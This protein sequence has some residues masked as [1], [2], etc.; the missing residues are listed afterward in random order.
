MRRRPAVAGKLLEKRTGAKLGIFLAMP[1]GG[2]HFASRRASVKPSRLQ[3]KR[4]SGSGQSGNAGSFPCH[5]RG[6]GNPPGHGDAGSS[7]GKSLTSC[8]VRGLG[9]TRDRAAAGKPSLDRQR[10][11]K[12]KQTS[13]PRTFCATPDCTGWMFTHRLGKDET[14]FCFKCNA[15]Y[16]SETRSKVPAVHPKAKC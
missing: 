13:T 2:A 4:R 9:E 15:E 7:V 1:R 16:P 8:S 14:L 12:S 11:Q 3:F 5:T 6:K 10:A